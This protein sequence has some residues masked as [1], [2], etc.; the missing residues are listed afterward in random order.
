[1]IPMWILVVMLSC[2]INCGGSLAAVNNAALSILVK[3]VAGL[4]YL[5]LA[6]TNVIL[7][8]MA[9]MAAKKGDWY[10]YPFS[11]RMIK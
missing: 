6:G 9:A 10:K 3:C 1:M 5:A 7:G 4:P 8:I 11:F 2:C